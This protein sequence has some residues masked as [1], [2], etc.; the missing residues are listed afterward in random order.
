MSS[1]EKTQGNLGKF[2]LKIDPLCLFVC[3]NLVL[4][5]GISYGI[6]LLEFLN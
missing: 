5:F 4:L 1:I 6:L 3:H 2:P